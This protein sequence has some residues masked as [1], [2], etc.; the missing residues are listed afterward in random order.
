MSKSSFQQIKKAA[1]TTALSNIFNKTYNEDIYSSP[2]EESFNF[3][4]LIFF[5]YQIN[6]YIFLENT[7]TSNNCILHFSSF[8]LRSYMKN[9]SDTILDNFNQ[10]NFRHHRL[11]MLNINT[12]V[13]EGLIFLDGMEIHKEGV[14]FDPYS[15]ITNISL[16]ED[17]L[18]DTYISLNNFNFPNFY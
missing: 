13:L 9:I 17:Y 8:E 10:S 7:D 18:I 2:G 12:L 11:I 14:Y 5:D 3:E 16:C 1:E 6:I 4:V 15:S